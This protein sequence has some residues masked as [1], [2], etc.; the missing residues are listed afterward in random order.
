MS[1]GNG[2]LNEED[3]S[4]LLRLLISAAAGESE[5]EIRRRL[6]DGLCQM[7]D[8]DAWVWTLGCRQQPGEPQVWVGTLYGGFSEERFTAYLKALENPK[9]VPIIEPFFTALERDG[10]QVTMTRSDID[11]EGLSYRSGVGEFWESANIGHLI[12]CGRPVDESSI[13]SIGLYRRLDQSDF[14]ER[15]KRITHLIMQEVTWLHGSG[16]SAPVA[17][18]LASLQPR[19]RVVLNMLIDGMSRK[20]IARQLEITENTVSGY[21]RDIYKALDV[22]SQPELMKLFLSG[23]I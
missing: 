7:I 23:N 10:E 13:S 19:Q 18:T 14:T 12:M 3:I 16:W 5:N 8:V 17:K 9:M 4:V 6:M 21:V 1:T 22:N 20:Q 11:P 15:E 2:Q